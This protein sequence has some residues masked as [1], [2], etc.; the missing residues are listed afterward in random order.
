MDEEYAD[1][2]FKM[3]VNHVSRKQVDSDQET[4]LSILN[5]PTLERSPRLQCLYSDKDHMPLLH[6]GFLSTVREYPDTC[7]GLSVSNYTIHHD[8]STAGY[9][10]NGT[11]PQAARHHIL[12]ISQHPVNSASIYGTLSCTL[13][14]LVSS[15]QGRICIL[16]TT[17]RCTCYEIAKYRSR[18]L[19]YDCLDR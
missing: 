7:L 16:P 14:L 1:A 12:R 5:H 4:R 6:S 9:C 2:A 3:L 15:T 18:Y 17:S 13:H 19:L 11:S 10:H 8:L